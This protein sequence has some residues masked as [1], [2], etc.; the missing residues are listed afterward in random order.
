MSVSRPVLQM[1]MFQPDP[2]SLFCTSRDSR[3]CVWQYAC[4]HREGLVQNISEC[5]FSVEHMTGQECLGECSQTDFS[6]GLKQSNIVKQQWWTIDADDHRRCELSCDVFGWTTSS[7]HVQ[8]EWERV[9]W[10]NTYVLCRMYV[11]IYTYIDMDVD[12]C[13]F[14]CSIYLVSLLTLVWWSFETPWNDFATRTVAQWVRKR[15]CRAVRTEQLKGEV[16]ERAVERTNV[17]IGL[18]RLTV[19]IMWPCWWKEMVPENPWAL[20][21]C[22]KCS[23]DRTSSKISKPI[24]EA[25]MN[26]GRWAP[27]PSGRCLVVTLF[28]SRKMCVCVHTTS[29]PRFVT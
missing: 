28:L 29:R 14:G 19:P 23:F 6:R 16:S 22:R 15:R 5:V 1:F 25:V 17:T 24:W 3:V 13:P 4:S 26:F 18:L 7:P 8:P 12:M 2:T 11:Y 27:D 9:Q 10:L 21:R 20:R